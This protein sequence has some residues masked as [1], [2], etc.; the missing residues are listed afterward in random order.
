MLPQFLGLISVSVGTSIAAESIIPA[1]ADT[2]LRSQTGSTDNKGDANYGAEA[3]MEIKTGK[4][5]AYA[6]KG[7]VRFP[8]EEVKGPVKDAMLSFT[9]LDGWF[10]SPDNQI[11]TFEVY[12]LN[13]AIDRN[14]VEGTGETDVQESTPPGSVTGRNAPGND[15]LTNGVNFAETTRVGSFTISGKGQPGEKVK[16]E[17]KELTE[18]VTRCLGTSATFFVIRVESDEG[19]EDLSVIHR[20]AT[21]ENPVFDGPELMVV[22]GP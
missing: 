19:R 1:D 15:Y 7:I 4:E 8:L 6:R 12:G 16:V 11:W 21:K 10:Q 22:T 18:F 14:W 17:G 2:Y 20:L 3:L 5:L 9:V 13:P